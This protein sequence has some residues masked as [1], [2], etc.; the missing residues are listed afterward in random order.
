MKRYAVLFTPGAERQLFDLYT[1]VAG[2]S[3]EARAGNRLGD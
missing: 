2:D 3:G 1:Y